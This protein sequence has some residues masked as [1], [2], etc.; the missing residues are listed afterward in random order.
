MSAARDFIELAM[1]ECGASISKDIVLIPFSQAELA[2]KFGL[3]RGT[4][5]KYLLQLN[6]AVRRV[7]GDG[8]YVNEPVLNHV[9]TAASQPPPAPRPV[10][11]VGLVL[12]AMTEALATLSALLAPDDN[13]GEGG[14]QWRA[15]GAQL[16]KCA[17]CA[18]AEGRANGAHNSDPTPEKPPGDRHN[19]HPTVSASPSAF[20][21]LG[22]VGGVGSSQA[23]YLP[24]APPAVRAFG[25]AQNGAHFG[26]EALAAAEMITTRGERLADDADIES[27]LAP[28]ITA[29]L[30][31][32]P[33]LPSRVDAKGRHW[34]SLYSRAELDALAGEALAKIRAGELTRSATAWMV[35][36]A[37]RG[38]EVYFAVHEVRP[39]ERRAIAP[40]PDIDQ[41]PVGE[42]WGFDKSNIEGLRGAL[43]SE[44]EA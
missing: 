9:F 12:E 19:P 28:V 42:A 40:E 4:V 20:A 35:A 6:G 44:S 22:G 33:P 23:T 30:R 37:R 16:P 15:N 2:R 11:P 26:Q 38:E 29:S 3:S 25:G 18:P 39:Q 14:A 13:D 21:R 32:S 24:T 31:C 34:L 1:A 36:M 27:A 8:I 41:V 7:P 5:A 10:N 17:P 43:R